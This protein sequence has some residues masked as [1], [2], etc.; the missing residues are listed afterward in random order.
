M[1][2]LLALAFVLGLTA[3]SA[4]GDEARYFLPTALAA[5][6]ETGVRSG[7][8]VGLEAVPGGAIVTVS[9]P[10]RALEASPPFPL[11]DPD[12][13]DHATDLEAPGTPLIAREV[14]GIRTSAVT[15]LAALRDVVELVSRL[16]VLDDADR[17]P[18]DAVSVLRRGRGRCSGRAN[19]AVGMLRVLGIPARPVHGV[20]VSERGAAYHRWGEA[21]LGPLGWLAFDPGGSAGLVD[22]RH[23]PLGAPTGAECLVGVSV[24]AVD[25]RGFLALPVERG[26]RWLP[27]GGATL[28][29]IVPKGDEGGVALLVAPDGSRWIRRGGSEVVFERMLPGRYRLSWS[30]ERAGSGL[31]LTLGQAPEVEV[32]LKG[33]G[34]ARS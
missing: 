8:A 28:R 24:V 6:V 17:G 23:I 34:A 20:V 13:G 15:T 22:V 7:L 9:E 31:V 5:R 19:L 29:C 18:Q 3:A 32:E 21:W 4:P 16:V 1:R 25:E 2:R 14:A 11:P 27:S 10:M 30:G 12:R 33:E 26:V